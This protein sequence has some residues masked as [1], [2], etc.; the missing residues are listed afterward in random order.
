MVVRGKT[1][2]IPLNLCCCCCKVTS[3]LSDSVRPIGSSPPGSRKSFFLYCWN[4]LFGKQYFPKRKKVMEKLRG[5]HLFK[6][7]ALYSGYLTMNRVK[8]VQFSFW[9][10]IRP[11]PLVCSSICF[12]HFITVSGSC[13]FLFLSFN[14]FYKDFVNMSKT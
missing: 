11:E 6:W 4:F 2:L 10:E 3:V 7:S 13:L 5:V 9:S 14:T 12:V 1:I 8:T